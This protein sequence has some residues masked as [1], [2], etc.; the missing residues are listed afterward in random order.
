MNYAIAEWII[1]KELCIP[2]I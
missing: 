1:V 2:K